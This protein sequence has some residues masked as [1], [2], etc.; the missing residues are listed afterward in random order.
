[1][2]Q[3]LFT[4]TCNVVCVAC[5]VLVTC[6]TCTVQCFC[7]WIVAS[8]EIPVCSD[9]LAVCCIQSECLSMAVSRGCPAALQSPTVGQPENTHPECHCCIYKLKFRTRPSTSADVCKAC[10]L[11][12][13]AVRQDV[14]CAARCVCCATR[15]S[16]H[17]RIRCSRRGKPVP[18]CSC[19]RA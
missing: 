18:G 7:A 3:V 4:G 16:K 8:G 13:Y 2:L 11:F 10:V 1:M 9:V 17:S 6:V 5:D 15:R 14:C 12:V 19:T